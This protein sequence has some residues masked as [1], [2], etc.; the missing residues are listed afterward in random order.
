M[1]IQLHTRCRL[2]CD[3]DIGS[4][5]SLSDGVSLVVR[6]MPGAR[7][8]ILFLSFMHLESRRRAGREVIRVRVSLPRVLDEAGPVG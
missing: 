7:K 3:V 5:R 8:W 4:K 1:H 6:R 2:I